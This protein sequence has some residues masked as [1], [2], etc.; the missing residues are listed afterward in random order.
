MKHRYEH[1]RRYHKFREG[2]YW[3]PNDDIQNEQLDIGHHMYKLVLDD[4]LLLAPVGDDVK[5]ALDVGCGTGIWAIE[6]AE[7]Y[8]EAEVVGVDL[9]PIQPSVVPS[10]CTFVVDDCTQSWSFPKDEFDLVHIRALFGSVSDWPAF[11]KEAY[12]HIKPGGW[13]NQFETSI[14]PKSDDGSLAA[15][16]TLLEWAR[17][18]VEAANKFGKSLMVIDDMKQRMVEA[19]FE[20]VTEVM[21]KVPLGTWPS[22]PKLKEI[23]RWDLMYCYQGCEGWA[24]YLLTHVMGWEIEEVKKLVERYKEALKDPKVHSYWEL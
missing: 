14:V 21:Y 22:N 16:H 19:G 4:R 11:Y 18:F 7:E 13:I 12:D 24:L 5:K 1:G 23:G 15:D 6:F 17:L 8:P 9:S 2:A 20:D 3:G 10:N